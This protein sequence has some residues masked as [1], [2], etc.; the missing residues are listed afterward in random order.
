[1]DD[2]VEQAH[3][4]GALGAELVEQEVVELGEFVLF[5]GGNDEMF[6]TVLR[7]ALATLAVA[8]A[9][10]VMRMSFG[11]FVSGGRSRD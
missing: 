5:A 6:G 1:V 11:K 3:F 4:E 7:D 8:R 10:A 9:D 2:R